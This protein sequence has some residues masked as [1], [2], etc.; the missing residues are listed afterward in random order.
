LGLTGKKHSAVLGIEKQKTKADRG[1]N[2][3]PYPGGFVSETHGGRK[4]N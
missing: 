4:K 1:S 2:C 3:D